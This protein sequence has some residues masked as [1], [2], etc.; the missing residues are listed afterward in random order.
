MAIFIF[1]VKTNP[2]IILETFGE[3]EIWIKISDKGTKKYAAPSHPSA[4]VIIFKPTGLIVRESFL[5][6]LTRRVKVWRD[7]NKQLSEAYVYGLKYFHVVNENS[8]LW[9]E[10]ICCLITSIDAL[11]RIRRRH[12]VLPNRN[13]NRIKLK[14]TGSLQ[15]L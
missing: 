3:A 10:N 11:A 12:S 4:V 1:D 13:V 14:S 15:I 9:K 5:L 7:D 6:H 2:R 8:W